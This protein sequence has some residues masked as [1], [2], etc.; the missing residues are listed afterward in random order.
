[1]KSI[2]LTLDECRALAEKIL[3]SGICTVNQLFL[4]CCTFRAANGRTL[5][6]SALRKTLTLTKLAVSASF[7]RD[8][9]YKEF[10]FYLA[11]NTSLTDV[12]IC[13]GT[14]ADNEGRG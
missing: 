8:L 7:Q 5:V 1:L 12:K 3:L 4:D 6:A 13:F 10:L 14:E 9:F 2:D 11:F